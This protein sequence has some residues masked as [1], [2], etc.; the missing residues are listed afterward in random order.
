MNNISNAK[1]NDP[2]GFMEELKI[3]YDAVL[4]IVGKVPNGT[5][6]MIDLLA[7]EVAAVDWAGYCA[8]LRTCSFKCIS[9]MM[10]PRRIY[11]FCIHKETNQRIQ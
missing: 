1:L 9:R 7:A 2:H 5:G 4:A 10:L 6:P 3:K 11:A 8:I